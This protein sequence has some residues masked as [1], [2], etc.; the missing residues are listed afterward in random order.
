MTKI[1][2][3]GSPQP[4]TMTVYTGD[5]WPTWSFELVDENNAPISDIDEVLMQVKINKMDADFVKELRLGDGFIKSG[6][7][8]TF[9]AVVDMPAS[10]RK[11][12]FS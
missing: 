10:S 9:D 4:W 1:I 3:D 8:I 6:N 12:Y 2:T 5:R 7:K 11:G